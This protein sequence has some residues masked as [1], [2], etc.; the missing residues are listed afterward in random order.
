MLN[1]CGVRLHP[2]GKIYDFLS[3][4]LQ[5]EPGDIVVVDTVH[6]HKIGE[7][8]TKITQFNPAD[9]EEKE[10]KSVVRIATDKDFETEKENM[11]LA[12]KAF[13]LCKERIDE[14]KLDMKLFKAEYTLDRSKIIFSYMSEQ[15]IDFRNLVHDLVPQLKTRIE[16]V[17]VGPREHAKYV[18]G[19]GICG[20]QFCCQKFMTA[21][22][23]VSIKMAKYQGLTSNPSKYSGNCGKLLCCIKHEESAYEYAHGI[24][25]K[26]NTLTMTPDGPGKIIAVNMLKE[27]LTVKIGS[28]S[29]F[30]IK[31][32]TVADIRQL[33]EDERNAYI[34]QKRKEQKALEESQNIHDSDSQQR[35]AKFHEESKETKQPEQKH[36]TKEFKKD[37]QLENRNEVNEEGEKENKPH[38]IKGK[39]PKKFFHGKGKPKGE[40]KPQGKQ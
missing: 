27:T 39:R 5:L 20:R 1:V 14:E 11:E 38:K 34:I 40:S 22:E 3:G 31:S 12:K 24:M 10:F 35:K 9:S 16:M 21:F 33:T 18:G 4:K 36:E 37:T 7:V 8:A 30:E 2:G 32:Y 15:R 28:E 29:D 13:A 19:I 17:Q 6:G 26:S 23:P 25:P